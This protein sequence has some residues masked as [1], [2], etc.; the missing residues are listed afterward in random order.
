MGS[1]LDGVALMGSTPVRP[2]PGG[3]IATKQESDSPAEYMK[4]LVCYRLIQP[5][6]EWRLHR[7][8]Y[9]NS[10]V[11]DLLGEEGEAVP[12]QNLYR[13]LDKLL[14]HKNG[15][16]TFLKQR[17]QDMFNVDFDVL[18]YDLPSTYFECDPPGKGKR[19]YSRAM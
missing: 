6:S 15:M 4:I 18:L 7:E 10:A 5:G 17:W 12:Y 16:F 13:C 3:E 8:W 19:R 2:L 11:G 14:A 1:L 9:G